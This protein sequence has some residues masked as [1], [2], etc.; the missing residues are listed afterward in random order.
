MRMTKICL[1]TIIK[2][3]WPLIHAMRSKS[4]RGGSMNISNVRTC[5]LLRILSGVTLFGITIIPRCRRFRSKTWNKGTTEVIETVCINII[6]EGDNSHLYNFIF[7]IFTCSASPCE[8]K[9]MKSWTFQAIL[10]M[11]MNW[12]WIVHRFSSRTFR[13]ELSSRCVHEK[14]MNRWRISH[15][16]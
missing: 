3:I 7:Y 4:W 11:F 13:N 9:F 5:M 1:H 6:L 16:S 2:G 14:F 10:E 15:S 8:M 12:N